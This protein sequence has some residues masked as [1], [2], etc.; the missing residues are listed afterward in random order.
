MEDLDLQELLVVYP[1][2]REY[3]LA[4]GIRAVPLASLCGMQ[5]V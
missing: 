5:A 2:K 4:D 3:P 1:G